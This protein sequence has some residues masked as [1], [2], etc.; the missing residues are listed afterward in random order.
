MQISAWILFQSSIKFNDNQSCHAIIFY[1][2]LGPQI[3]IVPPIKIKIMSRLRKQL[4]PS[5]FL[6][7]S[8]QAPTRMQ[9]SAGTPFQSSI[10]FNDNQSCD[11]TCGSLH[12]TTDEIYSCLWHGKVEWWTPV[13]PSWARRRL[14]SKNESDFKLETYSFPGYCFT[15][16]DRRNVTGN[17]N[18]NMNLRGFPI[19]HFLPHKM[20]ANILGITDNLFKIPNCQIY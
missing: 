13:L 17:V 19:S 5:H 11:A 18:T 3:L 20:H 16:I 10:K 14:P 7:I 8:S 1:D 15:R 6:Q 12:L 2:F 9:I 4:S